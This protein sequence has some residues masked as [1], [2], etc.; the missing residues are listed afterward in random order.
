[1]A[2]LQ[3]QY[4]YKKPCIFPT[5]EILLIR[6]SFITSALYQKGEYM[7]I[8]VLRKSEKTKN[9]SIQLL[10]KGLYKPVLI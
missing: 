6:I 8:D 2:Q 3:K 10:L 5:D 7:Q 4:A 9:A 1:M